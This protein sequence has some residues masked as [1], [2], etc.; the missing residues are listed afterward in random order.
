VAQ[1]HLVSSG[2]GPFYDGALHLLLSPADLLGL[3]A[4]V[5]LA[6]LAGAGAGRWLT[7]VLPLAWLGGGLAGL[8]FGAS[9]ELP[10]LDVLW[11]VAFGALVAT[12]LRL[13]PRIIGLMAL[14]YGAL[15]GLLNGSA[16]WALGAGLTSLLGI[17]TTVL[18]IAL[19]GSAFVVSL[20]ASWAL[21]AVRVAGSWVAAV[22]M[23]MLGWTLQVAGGQV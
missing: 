14:I 7:L 3:I 8:E 16:L 13:A 9:I 12:G 17:A 15:Q 4:L 22:G 21:V 11:L 19:L 6:G 23:L 5:L 2:L 10:W 18:V 20:R 1:A